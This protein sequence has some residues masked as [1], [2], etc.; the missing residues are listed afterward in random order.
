MTR[1]EGRT[2]SVYES[3]GLLTYFSDSLQSTPRSVSVSLDSLLQ[4]LN[5]VSLNMSN[6]LEGPLVRSA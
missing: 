4:R 2:Y 5:K 6:V 3:P 1:T